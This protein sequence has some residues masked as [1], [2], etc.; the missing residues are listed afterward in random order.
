MNAAV[1]EVSTDHLLR[2]QSSWF[3]RE[4]VAGLVFAQERKV[5][6]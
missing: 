6:C 1:A 5:R 3:E 2:K 4:A